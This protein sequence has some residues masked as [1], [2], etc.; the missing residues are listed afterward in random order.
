MSIRHLLDS[1][2]FSIEH[3]SLN[4][5]DA[6]KLVNDWGGPVEAKEGGNRQA[7]AAA[8]FRLAGRRWPWIPPHEEIAD[9]AGNWSPSFGLETFSPEYGAFWQGTRAAYEPAG[10]GWW[11]D[12]LPWITGHALA[13]GMPPKRILLH[14]LEG[15]S[16]HDLDVDVFPWGLSALFSIHPGGRFLWADPI[17]PQTLIQRAASHPLVSLAVGREVQVPD[18]IRN[19]RSLG[20]P[21]QATLGY[22]NQRP[23]HWPKWPGG[24]HGEAVPEE[25]LESLPPMPKHTGWIRYEWYHDGS[26]AVGVHTSTASTRGAVNLAVM[27]ADRT[28]Q[29]Y[30]AARD[31]GHDG[32]WSRSTLSA[33]AD[34]VLNDVDGGELA[35]PRPAARH[36]IL[37]DAGGARIIIRDGAWPTPPVVRPPTHEERVLKH[38]DDIDYWT[39]QVTP[40]DGINR[41]PCQKIRNQTDA[42][43]RA[44]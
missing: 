14:T 3:E 28:L 29:Y 34:W 44:L 42:I 16:Q 41:R 30:T 37:W 26:R 10:F 38:L 31:L 22:S 18:W 32:R 2:R 24:R 4:D 13:M 9:H 1:W 35:V 23:T 12:C 7:M 5:S 19:H 20:P 40:P 17:T 21:I 11:N 25:Y 33:S 27:D 43:R 39:L 15:T 8:A 6:R 36:A